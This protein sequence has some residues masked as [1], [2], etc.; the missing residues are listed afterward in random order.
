MLTLQGLVPSWSGGE[1]EAQRK[2]Y[3]LSSGPRASRPKA[4]LGTGRSPPDPSLVG[5]YHPAQRVSMQGPWPTAGKRG[6]MGGEQNLTRFHSPRLLRAPPGSALASDP[7][8]LALPSPCL[9]PA[10]CSHP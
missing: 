1:W 6:P 7:S 10:G 2:G 5:G 9:H 4:C 3:W 8:P